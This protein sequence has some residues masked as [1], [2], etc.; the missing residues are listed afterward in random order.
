MA[1]ESPAI[2][3]FQ[4]MPPTLVLAEALDIIR[5]AVQASLRC[6][7]LAREDFQIIDAALVG[8]R[9]NAT[10]RTGSDLDL[11]VEYRGRMREDDVF[12]FFGEMREEGALRLHGVDIDVNP[13][14]CDENG[15]LDTWMRWY[16]GS[17]IRTRMS[18]V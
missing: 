1:Q 16:T 14:K 3:G 15:S 8:S 5:E 6:G 4:G 9:V 7:A 12:N 2:Q 11:V 18:S 10:A 13:V 17:A